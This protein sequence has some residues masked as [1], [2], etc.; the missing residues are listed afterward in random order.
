MQI[1]D[2]NRP[3]STTDGPPDGRAMLK[4]AAS[5]VQVL[6]TMKARP[7]SD[8]HRQCVSLLRQSASWRGGRG[9]GARGKG[10]PHGVVSL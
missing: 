6:R 9:D 8:L 2:T 10:S 5:A 1:P 4:L 3:H 7:R